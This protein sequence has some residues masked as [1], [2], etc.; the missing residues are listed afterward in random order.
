M[1][2]NSINN[3]T[4]IYRKTLGGYLMSKKPEKEKSLYIPESKDERFSRCPP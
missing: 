3:L 1:S 2:E 4:F